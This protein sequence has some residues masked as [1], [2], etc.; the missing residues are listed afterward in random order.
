MIT[1]LILLVAGN[2][3]CYDLK[4][5]GNKFHENVSTQGCCS[6]YSSLTVGE[7]KNAT[8]LYVL[9]HILLVS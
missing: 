1:I 7:D 9:K 4:F 6:T 5:Y 3:A 2:W 8:S